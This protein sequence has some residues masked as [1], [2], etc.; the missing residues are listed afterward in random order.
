MST[1]SRA[2]ANALKFGDLLVRL[3]LIGESDLA[4][5]LKVAPQFGLP[6]GRTLVLTGFLTDEELQLVVELQ[7]LIASQT[8][9]IDK[10]RGAVSALKTKKLTP[11]IRA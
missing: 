7:P 10:A 11:L 2:P 6:I 8:L 9:S 4:D 5:A 3:K 1:E